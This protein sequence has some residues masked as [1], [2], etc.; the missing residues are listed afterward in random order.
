[1]NKRFC[2]ECGEETEHRETIKQK[3]SKYGNSKKSSS[4]HSSMAFL[5]G[6]R[7]LYQEELLWS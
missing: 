7:L 6:L 1:M 5:V 3:P 2:E 4:K